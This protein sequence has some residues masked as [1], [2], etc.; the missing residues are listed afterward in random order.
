MAASCTCILSLCKLYYIFHT[1]L[2][3]ATHVDT[4]TSDAQLCV[5]SIEC[6]DHA[7]AALPHLMGALAVCSSYWGSL[8]PLG[9]WELM[10]TDGPLHRH[11][12][13]KYSWSFSSLLSSTPPFPRPLIPAPKPSP[14]SL[15]PPP[16]RQ[17]GRTW[18]NTASREWA[19]PQ[20]SWHWKYDFYWLLQGH[21]PAADPCLL[22]SF[23]K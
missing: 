7:V 20:S 11:H 4:L 8:P 17:V 16:L 15:Y 3:V 23:R 6:F 10:G 1:V 13:T 14:P 2:H 5:L 12:H 22:Y 19:K 18:S 21:S 9:N